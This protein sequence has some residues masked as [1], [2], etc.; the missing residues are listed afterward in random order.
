MER[1]VARMVEFW[2]KLVSLDHCKTRDMYFY[3]HKTWAYGNEPTYQAD[4]SGY[5]AHEWSG[6]RRS[7]YG[8]ALRDLHDFLVRIIGE[9]K[10]WALSVVDDPDEQDWNWNTDTARESLKLYDEYGY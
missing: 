4:H 8:E 7:T 3:I 6:P 5:V 2:C 10:A 1:D 9:Q